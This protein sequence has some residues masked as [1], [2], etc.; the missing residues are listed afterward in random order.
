MRFPKWLSSALLIALLSLIPLLLIYIAGSGPPDRVWLRAP[1]WSRAQVVG[2]TRHDQATPLAVD[3]EGGA[4]LFLVQGSATQRQPQISALDPRAAPRWELPLAITHRFLRDPQ[5]I[6]D[7]RELVLFWIGDEQLYTARIDPA[8]SILIEP[9]V[10]AGTIEVASYSATS[11]ADGRIDA[12][13]AGTAATPGL[14]ALALDRPGAAP[15]QITATGER[16]QLRHD[17]AGGLHAIWLMRLNN[18]SAELVYAQSGAGGV[19]QAAPQ[20]IAEVVSLGQGAEVTGPWFGIDATHGYVGWHTRITLG[21]RSG[22]TFTL[23]TAFPLAQPTQAQAPQP[24]LVPERS[25]LA[26][27]PLDETA[28]NSGARLPLSA[29][30]AGAVAP[31]AS[32]FV[33]PTP[34]PELASACEGLVSIGSGQRLSQVCVLFWRDGAPTG[35]QNLT[36]SERSAFTPALI[37]DPAGNL[38]LTWRELRDGAAVVYF[39]GTAPQVV[40][41]LAQISLDDLLRLMSNIV[42]GM[43]AGVIFAPFAA[44]LWFGPPLVLLIPRA[45]LERAGVRTGRWGVAVSLLMALGGYWAVKVIIL[46]SV[47]TQVPFA[48]WLPLLS[49][50]AAL[51]LQI[52][53]PPVITAAALYGAWAASYRRGVPALLL[54]VLVYCTIDTIMTMAIY[55][56]GLFSR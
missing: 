37:S 33:N 41:G 23:H 15:I 11:A 3:A 49:S 29:R 45:L 8:G 42:F 30:P 27:P 31:P 16:P 38:Y 17:A 53:T 47:L 24:L 10:V 21:E 40:Q 46:G 20:S 5:I 28:L 6:W 32:M 52:A 50:G 4:Y 43:L 56:A 2:V 54:F 51:T 13:V 34:A 55:G 39:A 35:F 36:L 19:L 9:T 12:W 14:Y 48:N 18:Q 22:Q 26:Y 44:L 7:G 25:T 1:G